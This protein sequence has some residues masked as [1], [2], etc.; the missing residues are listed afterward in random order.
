MAQGTFP[1]GLTDLCFVQGSG[2]ALQ[3]QATDPDLPSDQSLYDVSL[4]DG[5]V[6]LTEDGKLLEPWG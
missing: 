6:V 3:I 4:Q 2:T 1:T 5:K